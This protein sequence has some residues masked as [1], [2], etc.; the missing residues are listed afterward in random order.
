M[1]ADIQEG[2]TFPDYELTDHAGA[3]RKLDTHND[4]MIAGICEF[5]G[6]LLF[7]LGLFSPLGSLLIAAS[8][9]TAIA[10]VHWPKIWVTEGG[11]ELPLTNLANFAMVT[12]SRYQQATPVSSH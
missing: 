4:P 1:R 5:G 3:R 12:P 2:A 9:V 8:M 11:I 6:G 10:K 7:A